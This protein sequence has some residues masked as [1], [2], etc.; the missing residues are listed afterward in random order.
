MISSR[1]MGSRGE[2]GERSVGG[3][4]LVENNMNN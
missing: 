1:G 2:I 4:E 3:G